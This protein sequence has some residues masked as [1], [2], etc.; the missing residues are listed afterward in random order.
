MLNSIEYQPNSYSNVKRIFFFIELLCT[1]FINQSLPGSPG[2]PIGPVGPLGP[3]SP[4]LLP[5]AGSPAGP[6]GPLRPL[7]P[8]GPFGP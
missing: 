7:S 5:S 8:G 2:A 4:F 6:F 1:S 3:G